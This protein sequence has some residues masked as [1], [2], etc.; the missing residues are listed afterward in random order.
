MYSHESLDSE[1]HQQ[2]HRNGIAGFV[3]LAMRI[4]SIVPNTAA[5]ERLFSKFGII[6]TKLRNRLHPDKVRKQVVVR[7]DTMLKFPASSSSWSNKRKFSSTEDDTSDEGGETTAAQTQ[8]GAIFEDRPFTSIAEELVAEAAA[9]DEINPLAVFAPGQPT[10]H[11]PSD[12]ACLELKNLFNFPA[13]GASHSSTLASLT[14]FWAAGQIGLLC[15]VEYHDM[16][17]EQTMHSDST[18]TN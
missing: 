5:T 2:S 4:V 7:V 16:I 18:P 10:S 13:A 1:G 17:Y 11:L 6:H 3:A 8:P 15:E 14:K 12:K 9:D